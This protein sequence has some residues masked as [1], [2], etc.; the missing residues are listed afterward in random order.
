MEL[1][2]SRCGDCERKLCQCS[3]CAKKDSQTKLNAKKE[4]AKRRNTTPAL[5]LKQQ[6]QPAPAPAPSAA[7][8]SV[9]SAVKILKDSAKAK[10]L[11]TPVLEQ[12]TKVFVPPAMGGNSEK[13][14]VGVI[15]SFN[16]ITRKY[17]V[18]RDLGSGMTSSEC[19]V[20]ASVL[21][22]LS[23]HETADVAPLNSI[24]FGT[25][26]KCTTRDQWNLQ[27]GFTYGMVDC[28]AVDFKNQPVWYNVWMMDETNSWF[29]VTDVVPGGPPASPPRSPSASESQLPL[30]LAPVDAPLPLVLAS[31]PEGRSKKSLTKE[32]GV[33]LKNSEPIHDV[34]VIAQPKIRL[35]EALKS[36][37]HNWTF[38]KI[39]RDGHCLFHSVVLALNNLKIP[40][41]PQT[42]QELRAACAKQFSEWK[43]VIPGLRNQLVDREGTILYQDTRGEKDRR[44]TVEEYCALL[45]TKMYGGMEEIQM[46]VQMYKVQVFVYSEMAGTNIHDLVPLPVLM[47]NDLS[48]DHEENAGNSATVARS[49]NIS[50]CVV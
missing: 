15:K 19:E 1:L 4:A 26:V 36:A 6:G 5:E 11:T 48:P 3:A 23:V 25:S 34:A 7:V 20:Q 16:K 35:R 47:N 41:C 21:T 32:F 43:G 10:Y 9:N 40:S 29:P 37:P 27:C 49:Q 38:F 12:G 31:N 13:G 46:I 44:I 45:R 42:Y 28:V 39:L 2:D 30:A 14:Y 18:F 8:A 17:V 50:H 33:N 22:L 24:A